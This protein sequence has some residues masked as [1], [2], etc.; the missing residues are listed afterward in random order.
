LI[1]SYINNFRPVLTFAGR[2]FFKLENEMKK[3]SL[4]RIITLSSH[5]PYYDF[6]Y[7]RLKIKANIITICNSYPLLAIFIKRS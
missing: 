6:Q 2:I 4:N 5:F 3:T 1:A 7:L